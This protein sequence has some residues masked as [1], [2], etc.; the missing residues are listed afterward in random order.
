MKK[1]FLAVIISVVVVGSFFAPQFLMQKT[2]PVVSE[3]IGGVSELPPVNP[4]DFTVVTN[5][6]LGFQIAL[7]N[8]VEFINYDSFPQRTVSRKVVIRDDGKSPF[9]DIETEM[10]SK[11]DEYLQRSFRMYIGDAKDEIGLQ[12]FVQKI[13]GPDCTVSTN[14]DKKDTPLG[15]EYPIDF[16]IVRGGIIIQNSPEAPLDPEYAPGCPFTGAYTS[17]WDRKNGKAA[18]MFLG[19]EGPLFRD[20]E[21][22]MYMLRSIT[23]F[24]K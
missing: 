13:S 4:K 15:V 14:F 18:L 6:R 20:N 23:F 24:G 8:T 12:K 16:L 10:F 17:R 7:P 11:K 21:S 2:G 22:D 1:E 5:T 9:V 19:Y 3:T